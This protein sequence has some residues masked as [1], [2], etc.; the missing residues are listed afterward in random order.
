MLFV[1]DKPR[2]QR[3]IALTRDDRKK[4]DQGKN[5]PFFR[6]EASGERIRLTGRQVE[7]EFPATVYEPGVL[8]VRVTMF[9]RALQVVTDTPTIAIQARGEGIDIENIHLAVEACDMLLYA[10]PARAPKVHPDEVQ[11]PRKMKPPTGQGWL[12]PDA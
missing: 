2:L 6:I 1:V 12:F 7:A 4:K 9:R 3:M 11:P 10:D 5:G 8:F